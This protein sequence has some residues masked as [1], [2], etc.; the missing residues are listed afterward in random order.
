M[1]IVLVASL[2]FLPAPSTDLFAT[3]AELQGL[4]DEISQATLQFET[5]TDVDQ[6]HAV[7]FA[8]DWAF[9]G[10]D[11]HTRHWDEVRAQ[12]IQALQAAP[13][14]SMTQPIQKLSIASDGTATVLVSLTTTRAIVDNEGRYGKKGA[15]YTLTESTPF[16]DTWLKTLRGWTFQSR[17]QL[18]QPKVTVDKPGVRLTNNT[19]VRATSDV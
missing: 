10:L 12:A 8:A 19:A 4:Y 18:G 15:P 16:R 14:D 5:E 9:I 3:Q 13:P 11:G 1:Y 7:F 2:F 6:F 17:Q